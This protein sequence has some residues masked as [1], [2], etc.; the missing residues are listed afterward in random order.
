MDAYR[1]ER[2]CEL[3]FK[4]IARYDDDDLLDRALS[5]KGV[6]EARG[7]RRVPGAGWLALVLQQLPQ[8]DLATCCAKG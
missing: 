6:C 1:S 5:E 7:R 8:A 3:S 2:S 4:M